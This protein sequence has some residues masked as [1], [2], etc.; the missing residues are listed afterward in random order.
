MFDIKKFVIIIFLF[1]SEISNAKIVNNIAIKIDNK[2]ITTFEIKNKILTTLILA[3][4]EINQKNI[5]GLK[6]QILDVLINLKLKEIELEKYDFNLDKYEL[7]RY[8]KQIDPGGLK[9]IEKKFKLNNISLDLFLQ[10]V[11]TELKWRK[12]IYQIYNDRIVIDQ[13]TIDS[14]IKKILQKENANKEFNLSEIEILN[15]NKNEKNKKIIEIKKSIE[16]IGFEGTALKFSISTS[17]TDKGKLGWIKESVLS[18]QIYNSV[19]KI[20][21]G[22]ITEPIEKANSLIFLKLND[23]R[24]LKNKI[25]E[26]NLR[27]RLITIKRNNLFNLYSSSFLS[28]LRNTNS[29]KYIK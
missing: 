14:E 13:Q 27:E 3:N 10:E 24:I 12:L 8:L 20:R 7:D 15:N 23:V 2:I 16:S 19:K 22:Q 28:K 25:D 4:R 6:E 17:A 11:K 18:E 9:E 21:P 5:D 1:Y 26:N 29:V